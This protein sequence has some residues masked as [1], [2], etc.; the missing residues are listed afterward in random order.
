[1]ATGETYRRYERENLVAV[2][3]TFNRKTEPELVRRIEREEH[4][5]TYLKRLVQMDVERE[6]RKAERDR[7][8]VAAKDAKSNPPAGVM[9][10]RPRETV[11]DA[12]RE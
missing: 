9:R 10:L 3:V 11:V 6:R 7:Q 2:R 1:M 8:R 4:R 5:A 12:G